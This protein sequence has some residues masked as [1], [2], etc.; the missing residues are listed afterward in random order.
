KS[1]TS[2][3]IGPFWILSKRRPSSWAEHTFGIYIMHTNWYSQHRCECNEV[4][5]DMSV[6]DRSV[7]RTPIRHHRIDIFKCSLT[8]QIRDKPRCWPSPIRSFIPDHVNLFL[9]LQGISLRN[10][11]SWSQPLDQINTAH[12]YRHSSPS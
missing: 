11:K 5:T 8:G 6:A 9:N 4:A 2:P 10:L 3:I 12:G 1:C 7:V